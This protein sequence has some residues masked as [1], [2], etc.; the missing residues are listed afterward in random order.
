MTKIYKCNN[1]DACG[2]QGKEKDF[3][4]V[5]EANENGEFTVCT[6]PRCGD[7]AKNEDGFIYFEE[8]Q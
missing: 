5:D 3:V 4:E 2:W 1:V 8:V 7:L 6:C